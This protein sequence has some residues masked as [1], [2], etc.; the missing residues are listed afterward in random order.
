MMEHVVFSV[1]VLLRQPCLQACA[2]H[3]A[4]RGTRRVV[5]RSSQPRGTCGERSCDVTSLLARPLR[6][7]EH[8]NFG[9]VMDVTISLKKA[10][11]CL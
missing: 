3:R 6:E 8:L 4:C 1:L 7:G 5:W 11:R 10:V 9:P 2:W